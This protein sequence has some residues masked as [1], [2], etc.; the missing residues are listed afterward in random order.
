VNTAEAQIAAATRLW[1]GSGT[2][3]FTGSAGIYTVDDGGQV[4]EDSAVVRTGIS[5]RNDR[6]GFGNA[7]AGCRDCEILRLRSCAA[8]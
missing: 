5:E 8:A 1:D 4:N 6:W 3:L 2:F 7:C